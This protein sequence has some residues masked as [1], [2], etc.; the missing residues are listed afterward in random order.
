MRLNDLKALDIDWDGNVDEPSLV[1]ILVV[2]GL[3][4]LD[5]GDEV[6]GG[7]TIGY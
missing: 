2:L 7:N 3:A 5:G 1:D 6:V 4:T